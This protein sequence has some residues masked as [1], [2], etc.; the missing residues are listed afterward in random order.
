MKRRIFIFLILGIFAFNLQISAQTN[1]N[2]FWT[3]FKAAVKAKDKNAV[4]ALTKFPLEMP[5]GMGS[6]KTRAQMNAR[7]DK[8]FNGEADA[9]RCFATEKPER[10]STARYSVACGFKNDK[11]GEAGK[12][13]VYSFERTKSGWKFAGLDNINE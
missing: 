1:F 13:I 12:P 3:K 5:Y 9:A 6:I 8:I 7:Y 11:S 4:A 2:A 10:D